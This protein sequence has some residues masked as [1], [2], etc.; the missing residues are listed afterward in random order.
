MS[1]KLEQQSPRREGTGDEHC[2]ERTI[3]TLRRQD[4]FYH[5]SGNSESREHHETNLAVDQ[6]LE[7]QKILSYCL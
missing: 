1:G 6:N 7:N 3:A 4:A 5:L 2:R